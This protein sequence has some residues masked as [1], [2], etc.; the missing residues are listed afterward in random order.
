MFQ[1]EVKLAFVRRYCP[2]AAGWKVLVDID[3][4]EE[5]RTG[6]EPATDEARQR[7]RLMKRDADR[8]RRALERLSVKVGGSRKRWFKR[9]GLPSIEGDRD[10]IAFHQ[11]RRVC[12]IAEVEGTSASQPEQ[13]LYKAIGQI[14]MAASSDK[15]KGWRRTLVL[16]VHGERIAE[17]LDRAKVL[18]KLASPVWP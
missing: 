3:A 9:Y 2:P 1:P 13:K 4:S 6:R 12:V 5:G 18:A 11:A 10:I 7:K 14:V 8:V 17:H 16:V 15:L